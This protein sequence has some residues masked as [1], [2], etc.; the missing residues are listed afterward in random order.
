MVPILTVRNF[1]NMRHEYGIGAIMAQL[2]RNTICRYEVIT[3][4]SATA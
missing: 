1:K 4:Y 2:W 3:T